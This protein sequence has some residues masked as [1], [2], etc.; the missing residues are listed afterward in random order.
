MRQRE[1]VQ[2]GAEKSD[3][4]SREGAWSAI[5]PAPQS[6]FQNLNAANRFLF[7][8]NRQIPELE[9]PLSLRKQRTEDR[10]NRQKIQ[11]CSIVDSSRR[12]HSSSHICPSIGG[13]RICNRE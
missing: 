7:G 9:T 2:S 12:P 4:Q 8:L 11:V 1:R 3:E 6:R 5:P 13:L 10:S